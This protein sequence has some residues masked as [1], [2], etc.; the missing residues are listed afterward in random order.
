MNATDLPSGDTRTFESRPVGE[1]QRSSASF[2][3]VRVVPPRH[4]LISR[5]LPLAEP[6]AHS[7]DPSAVN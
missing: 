2:H 6:S 5:T 1:N 4:V 7:N 3:N